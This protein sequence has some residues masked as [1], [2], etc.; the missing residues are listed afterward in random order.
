MPFNINE[1]R[2][3]M[4]LGGARPTNFQVTIQNPVTLIGD[5]AAPFMIKAAQLPP[6][7]VGVIEVPY[8]GRK[9][10]VAG[11]RIYPEWTVTVMNDETFLV[12]Q[13]FES[14][15]QSINSAEGNV[16]EFGSASPL[17]YKSQAQITQY[18]KTGVPIRTYNFS[19]LW[20]SEVSPIETSWET[21]DTIEEFT[22]TL[23]YDFW[24]VNAG[25]TGTISG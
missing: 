2:A 14:W 25:L 9:V 15:M 4:A 3:Q 13:G 11:D 22:V 19:G 10:K 16:R 7:Q 12:R 17:L 6:S 5:L 23:Q 21:V 20:P 24:E 1:M 8:F 18:S